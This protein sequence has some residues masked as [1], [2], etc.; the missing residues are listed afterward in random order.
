MSASLI[1]QVL[2]GGKGG[3]D[4]HC[5][6]RT[7]SQSQN[8]ISSIVERLDNVERWVISIHGS[9]LKNLPLYILPSLLF[10]VLYKLNNKSTN[11]FILDYSIVQNNNIE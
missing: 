3:I 5:T 8:Q 10:T 7:H 2:K 11:Q 9:S 6:H 1:R 4:T